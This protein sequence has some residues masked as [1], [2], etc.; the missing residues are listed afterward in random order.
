MIKRGIYAVIRI[1]LPI[2]YAL[3]VWFTSDRSLDFY[4]GGLIDYFILWLLPS[5]EVFAAF[6][7]HRMQSDI[8]WLL[9]DSNGDLKLFEK[10]VIRYE[11]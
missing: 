5:N 3:S 10:A 8:G 2:D 1:K 4:V 6:K 11:V 9:T 7:V